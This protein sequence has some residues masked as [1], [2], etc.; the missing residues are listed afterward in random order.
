MTK[1]RLMV[2]CVM[3][4][5]IFTLS[6]SHAVAA[7]SRHAVLMYDVNTNRVLH[8]ENGY[9]QRYPAS[10]TKMMTLYMLFDALRRGKVSMN[11]RMVASQFAASQPQTNV[12]IRRGETILVSQAIYALIIRSANDIAVVVAEHLGGSQA[13][14]ALMMNRKA[15]ELGMR[16][17]VFKNPHGL[18]DAR[19]HTT[20]MDMALLGAALRKHF[21]QYYEAF[22]AQSFTFKGVRYT[23]H[24]RVLNRLAGVDGIKTGYINASGFNLVSSLKRGN[25]NIVAV[26]MGGTTAAERDGRM[27]KLLGQTYTRL[28][29][30]QQKSG[31]VQVADNVPTPV[32]KPVASSATPIIAPATVTPV[33]VTTAH[34]IPASQ[35]IVVA[36]ALPVGQTATVRPTLSVNIT[37]VTPASNPNSA[38]ITVNMQQAARPTVAAAPAKNTL[39]YQLASY[40]STYVVPSVVSDYPALPREWAVQIGVFGDKEG[41]SRALS[42]L[43]EKLGSDMGD[44]VADVEYAQQANRSFHRAR[45][46][47][48]AREDA[49]AVCRKLQR[50]HQDCFVMRA[51]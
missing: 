22:K 10:L 8:Q 46:K 6:F 42:T 5:A 26:V 18:P 50:M 37:E 3:V 21:P 17:T 36:D 15:R 30:Q 31:G 48:L 14:F 29:A 1:Q 33:T 7:S 45:F 47:N 12:S 38:S 51:N 23:S 39:N 16:N 19:Q 34:I 11:T 49:N 27:V 44:A 4:M 9:A 32:L 35:R 20:A 24:N 25:I 13:N 28:A 43:S 40:G 2:M 41:A